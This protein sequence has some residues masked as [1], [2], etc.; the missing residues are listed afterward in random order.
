MIQSKAEIM[1]K[2]QN[3]LQ[4]KVFN[5]LNNKMLQTK[6]IKNYI[7]FYLET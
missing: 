1:P 3:A 5:Q 6:N 7:N 4:L 2:H